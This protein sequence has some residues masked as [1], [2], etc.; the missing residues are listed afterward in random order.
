[1]F[2]LVFL[3][4]LGG[5]QPAPSQQDKTSP[6]TP[7]T[8]RSQKQFSFYPGGKILFEGTVPGNLK[9]IGWQRATV[10]LE[11]ER[12]IYQ[13]SPEKAKQLADQY[14][15]QVR[16]GVS[17]ATIRATGPPQVDATM[18]INATLYV[19]KEKTDLVIRLIKGDLM[20]GGMNGWVEA[21]LVD[22]GLEAK[23][24]RGYFS[25]ITRQGDINIEMAGKRWEGMGFTAATERGDVTIRL[26]AQYSAALQ[27]E[28]KDGN[29]TIQYPEQT[30]EG[31]KVPWT[32][33]TRKKTRSLSA[34]V[35]G[36][37]APLRLHTAVGQVHVSTAE[38]P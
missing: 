28:T 7:Y 12:I 30:V 34:P 14:P 3:F 21:T 31:E 17:E 18:E 1:L 11:T 4:L 24:M 10:L 19:P 22:G 20:I 15:L 2:I 8:E 37:G 35:G 5:K 27:L 32:V 6:S 25:F 38:A 36:G 16:Y 13:L 23:S 33:V 26:P 29:I 9:V